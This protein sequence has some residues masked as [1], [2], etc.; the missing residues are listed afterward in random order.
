MATIWWISHYNH[1]RLISL[2]FICLSRLIGDRFEKSEERPLVFF[3]GFCFFERVREVDLETF[4]DIGHSGFGECESELQVG[5]RIA[6]HHELESMKT[7][8]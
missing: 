3:R 1:Y 4:L 2:H 7:R 5:D 8:Q 6:R